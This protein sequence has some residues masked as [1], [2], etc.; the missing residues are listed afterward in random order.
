M[1]NRFKGIDP[2]DDVVEML[3]KKNVVAI[4]K[5]DFYCAP[6]VRRRGLELECAR[7]EKR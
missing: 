1:A 5:C 7:P 3:K 6:L 4:M 2:L